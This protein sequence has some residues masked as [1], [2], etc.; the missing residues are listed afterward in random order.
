MP[1]PSLAVRTLP[2]LDFDAALAADL[3][4][5]LEADAKRAARPHRAARPPAANAPL[6]RP[7]APRRLA[8][9]PIAPPAA[10]TVGTPLVDDPLSGASCGWFDSSHELRRGLEVHEH[11][12]AAGVSALGPLLPLGWWLQWELDAALPSASSPR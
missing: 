11:D 7:A 6:R 2:P 3:A 4:A 8:L 1:T 12:G 9:Q 5:E 10:A